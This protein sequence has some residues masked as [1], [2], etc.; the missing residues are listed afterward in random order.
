MILD[1]GPQ[2][3][4]VIHMGDNTSPS[5]WSAHENSWA[6]CFRDPVFDFIKRLRVS[7][8]LEKSQIMLYACTNAN[9]KQRLSLQSLKVIHTTLK[10][11]VWDA[12]LYP[13]FGVEGSHP[14]RRCDIPY[15][16]VTHTT[17]APL[18]ILS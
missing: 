2:K 9:N 5:L 18:E 1:A 13:L 14:L 16:Q 6:G 17:K 12:S 8:S 10:Q 3:S 11:R 4:T 15:L 7:L